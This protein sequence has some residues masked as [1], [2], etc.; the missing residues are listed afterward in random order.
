MQRILIALFAIILSSC[1]D[2]QQM[3]VQ[4]TVKAQGGSE[5]D[6]SVHSSVFTNSGSELISSELTTVEV[7]DH[8]ESGVLVE[9]S[10][11][12]RNN[13]GGT[14]QV[15]SNFHSAFD[16]F[17]LIVTD[18]DNRLLTQLPYSFHQSPY[19]FEGRDFPINEGLNFAS[20]RFSLGRNA[21]DDLPETIRVRLVGTL[22]GS[23]YVRILSTN[24]LDV[25]LPGT[26]IAEQGG[27]RQPA[28]AVDSKPEDGKE[29][30]PESGAR[31]Q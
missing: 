7:V 2:G 19:S 20:L 11:E 12:L 27:A 1:G 25:V 3:D 30:K 21:P 22:P 16:S 5:S 29:P 26:K 23:G 24:T 6:E 17:E 9:C 31:S 15:E 13:T 10:L 18:S 4:D 14:L 8:G 28:T